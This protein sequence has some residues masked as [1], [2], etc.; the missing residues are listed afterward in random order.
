MRFDRH[1]F[2]KLRKLKNLTQPELANR[3]GVRQSQVSECESKGTESGELVAKLADALDCWM[4]YLY[5]RRL[6]RTPIRKA[7]SI[8]AFDFFEEKATVE[9]R[10]RCRRVIG[11]KAAPITAEDWALLAELINLAVPPPDNGSTKLRVVGGK[12]G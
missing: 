1:L 12:S 3:A 6:V 2:K 5:R 8:M 4:D 9:Q 7:A 11:H 10:A